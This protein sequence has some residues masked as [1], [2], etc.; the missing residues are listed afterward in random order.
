MRFRSSFFSFLHCRRA[1]CMRLLARALSPCGR[2]EE[3][4]RHRASS[5][6]R[7]R[8]AW[9]CELSAL[10]FRELKPRLTSAREITRELASTRRAL[11]TAAPTSAASQ[12]HA[13][14]HRARRGGQGGAHGGRA[15]RSMM[16]PRI[17]EAL[18]D[19]NTLEPWNGDIKARCV[20]KT[21]WTATMPASLDRVAS[22]CGLPPQRQ[23]AIRIPAC[24]K[25][26]D[27]TPDTIAT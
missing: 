13:S 2:V 20:V 15:A 12:N 3:R 14:H 16:R 26:S 21:G 18:P 10:L 23:A 19:I 6:K 9:T 25:Y 11:P 7:A 8:R 27:T 17:A 1:P 4:D 24:S 5:H 22:V